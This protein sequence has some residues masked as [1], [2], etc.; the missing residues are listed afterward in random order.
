MSAKAVDS[1]NKSNEDGQKAE[2][3]QYNE[4]IINQL[5]ELEIGSRSQIIQAMEMVN[6]KNNVEEIAEYLMTTIDNKCNQNTN[7][8]HNKTTEHNDKV[9]LLMSMGYDI[10]SVKKA[11][12][13]SNNDT[14]IAAQYLIDGV[15]NIN[16]YNYE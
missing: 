4:N 13:I 12:E 11:L 9:T 16:T 7:I 14:Q 1:T 3:Q 8:Q 2:Q 6:D 10:N 5:I 15:I